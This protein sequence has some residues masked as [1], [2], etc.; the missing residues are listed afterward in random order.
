MV[1]YIKPQLRNLLTRIVFLVPA[2]FDAKIA[3][4]EEITFEKLL[5]NNVEVVST[6]SWKQQINCPPQSKS[7]GVL[8]TFGQSNSAN[9]AEYLVTKDQLPD[10]I[11]YYDGRC[12]EAGSP[13]LGASNSRG[14]WMSLMAQSLVDNGT[15]EKVLLLS[16]GVGGSPVAAWS[17]GSVLNIRLLEHLRDVSS[18]YAVTDLFWHQGET[19]YGWGI[20]TA[21]YVESFE[22]M[23]RSIRRQGVNAPLFVSIASFCR[24]GNYPNS[25]VEAQFSVAALLEDVYVGVNT[26]SIISSDLRYDKCHFGK[27]GQEKAAIASAK[28][29]RE[30][31]KERSSL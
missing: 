10:V 15:Y 26:D 30:I 21:Q 17:A 23:V 7:M 12:Y 6:V 3:F 22:S 18:S 27:A 31:H 2:L 16:L 4:G 20:S 13:L 25:I 24:E 11:N 29:I 28:I 1:N 14:E 8:V 19:D 9:S 5:P